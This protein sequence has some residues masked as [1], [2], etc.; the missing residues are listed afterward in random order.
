MKKTNKQTK[1]KETCERSF[2]EANNHFNTIAGNGVTPQT[3][4]VHYITLACMGKWKE[5]LKLLKKIP[6]VKKCFISG[7]CEWPRCIVGKCF[8]IK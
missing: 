8:V 5:R 3:H 7:S 2:R 6:S 1:K 4:Q